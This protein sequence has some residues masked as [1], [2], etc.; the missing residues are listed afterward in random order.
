[1]GTWLD[2]RIAHIESQNARIV[3]NTNLG[4]SLLLLKDIDVTYNQLCAG[5]QFTQPS[6]VSVLSI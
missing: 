5:E 3:G 6:S 4:T 2:C 1:M